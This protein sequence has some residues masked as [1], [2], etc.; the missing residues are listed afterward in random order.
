M[1]DS[2]AS[3]DKAAMLSSSL[4][5]MATEKTEARHKIDVFENAF[6]SI[7]EATGVSDVNEVIQKIVSQESTTENL[8][9]LTRE[10]QSKIE[11]LNEQRRKI[12]ARV[13]EVKY[14]GVG[15]G[16][17]R[18][19]VDDH[20]DQL[21][22]A[23][24]RLERAR[25]KYERLN[26]VIIAMKAGVGHL[27]DKL[28]PVRDELGGKKIELNDETVA[29]VLRES[30]HIISNVLRRIKAGEG[31]LKRAKMVGGLSASVSVTSLGSADEDELN[32]S[33]SRPFNTRI[34]LTLE[35]DKD[36]DFFVENDG[37]VL[38]EADDDELTRDK[39]KRASAQI[40]QAVERKRRKPKKKTRAETSP[41]SPKR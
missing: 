5:S 38:L 1:T 26:K 7:K 23:S 21:A 13:E 19:M 17:R 30:E 12:K 34:D 39:V 37:P 4:K 6:R 28:E 33:S 40:L 10:N 16:H 35:E 25:L 29:E 20:E 22:N 41:D 8:I 24:A 27:Q 18:K 9:A 2:E 31:E 36:D 14:S 3:L 15:G 11:A 32:M